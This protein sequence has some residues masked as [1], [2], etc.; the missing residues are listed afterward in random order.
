MLAPTD[1]STWHQY[2]EDYYYRHY[3]EAF[4]PHVVYVSLKFIVSPIH[5]FPHLSV[6]ECFGSPAFEDIS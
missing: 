1:Q 6:L 3:R 5:R 4:K 2:S